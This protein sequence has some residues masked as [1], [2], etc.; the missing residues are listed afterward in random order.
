MQVLWVLSYLD[1]VSAATMASNLRVPIF[2]DQVFEQKVVNNIQLTSTRYAY[3]GVIYAKLAHVAATMFTT[4]KVSKTGLEKYKK[5][6]NGSFLI[7]VF[8]ACS[9]SMNDGIL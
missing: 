2:Q 8:K 9:C 5:I 3:Q 4:Y 1:T 6:L 7:A